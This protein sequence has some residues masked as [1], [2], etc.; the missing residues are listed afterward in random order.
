MNNNR[1]MFIIGLALG[2]LMCLPLGI[3]IA[4]TSLAIVC[5]TESKEDASHGN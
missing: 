4:N 1:N 5:Y 2:I 3:S